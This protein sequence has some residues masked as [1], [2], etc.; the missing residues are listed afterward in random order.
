MTALNAL[1]PGKIGYSF[2]SFMFGYGAT[3][4]NLNALTTNAATTGLEL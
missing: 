4:V 1:N 2:A 3:A